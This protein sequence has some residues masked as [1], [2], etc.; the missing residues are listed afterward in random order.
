MFLH[1]IG[2]SEDC[3]TT[4]IQYADDTIFFCEPKKSTLRN[5]RFIWKLFEWASE[6]RIN[7]NKSEVYYL[8]SN[9][10]KVIGLASVLGCRVGTLP[11]RYLGLPLHNKHLRK[12]DWSLLV[13]CISTKIEGWKAKL[14]SYGGRLTLINSVLSNLP[15]FFFSVFKA[16]KWVLNGFYTASRY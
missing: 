9:P 16:P 8:G 13:N 7:K 15:I 10:D 4:L 2:P 12:E 5:L 14:L 11:F 3:I 1:G 6:L